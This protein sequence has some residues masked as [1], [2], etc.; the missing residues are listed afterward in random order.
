MTEDDA[1]AIQIIKEQTN[2]A[3]YTNFSYARNGLDFSGSDYSWQRQTWDSFIN[4][5]WTKYRN[6]LP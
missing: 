5:M 4:E 1:Q 3:P 2:K 6:N